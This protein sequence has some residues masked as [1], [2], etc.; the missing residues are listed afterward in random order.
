MAKHIN[1]YGS[2]IEKYKPL[3]MTTTWFN[4]QQFLGIA[5]VD[6]TS[7]PSKMAIRVL[8]DDQFYGVY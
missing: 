2:G 4:Q 3:S 1:S 6:T 8:Q 7:E 5:F